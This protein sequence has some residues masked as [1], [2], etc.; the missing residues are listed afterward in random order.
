MLLLSLGGTAAILAQPFF[1]KSALDAISTAGIGDSATAWSAGWM[2]FFGFMMGVI[3]LTA[4][5]LSN[6]LLARIEA[7]IMQQIH[8]DVFAKAQRLASSFHVNEFAGSTARKITRGVDAV[9]T[10]IDRFWQNFLPAIILTVG[11]FI[12]LSTIAPLIGIA[13]TIGILGYS[14]LAI[15]LNL[16]LRKYYSWTDRQDTRVTGNLVDTLTGN[17]L[18]K[19]FAAEEREDRRHGTFLAEWKRRQLIGWDFSTVF[20]LIQFYY[21][22]A[23]ECVL[24]LLSIWLWYKGVFTAGSFLVVTLYV[25]LLWARLFDIG[26]HVRDYLRAMA[27]TEEMIEIAHKPFDVSDPAGATVLKSGK[28]AIVLENVRFRYENQ[29]H[30]VFDNFSLSIAAGER[31]ALVGHSGGGKSTL[32]KLL[33]R[34]YDTE[35]GTITIDEQN[36]AKH[37]QQ[38]VRS[39]ISLVSQDPILFHRSIRENIAYGRPDATDEEIIRAATLAHAH[40]FVERLPKGYDTLVGERGVKLSGGERQRVAIARAILADRPI[41]ILDEATSSLDSLSEKYIQEALSHLMKGRT[42]IVIAH[43]L[44]TIKKVDRIVV[45][46][47]GKIVE[48][49]THA[50]L[51]EKKDGIYR[52][53]YELQAGGFLGE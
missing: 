1:Y 50:A 43:R 14:V 16:I 17:M 40:E 46:D 35:S 24:L 36:I 47:D 37:T 34:L 39:V 23:L 4:E 7:P 19:S 3:S 18:V 26:R 12:V 13:L 21:L 27:H 32:I 31:I 11:F 22:L 44:S 49:G 15:W 25:W 52:N 10:I 30:A 28:G 33:L 48:E 53:F 2:V 6:Y 51:L 45:I 38:S 8:S 9:E 41:L 5:Q 20:V 29:P 42:T